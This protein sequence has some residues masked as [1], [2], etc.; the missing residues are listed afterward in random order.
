MRRG[1]RWKP[2]GQGAASSWEGEP[3]VRRPDGPAWAEPGGRAD[4]ARSPQG[5][6]WALQPPCVAVLFS[7]SQEAPEDI[8]GPASVVRGPSG[9][10]LDGTA[11][12]GLCGP[13]TLAEDARPVDRSDVKVKARGEAAWLLGLDNPIGGQSHA[14]NVA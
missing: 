9:L 14:H 3:R 6:T 13:S 8:G 7:A 4:E 5:D 12:G 10:S 1:C 11:V 2:A